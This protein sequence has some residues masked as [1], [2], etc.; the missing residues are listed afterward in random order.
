LVQNFDPQVYPSKEPTS[1]SAAHDIVSLN[2]IDETTLHNAAHLSRTSKEQA[3]T[4]S[5]LNSGGK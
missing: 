4:P 3:K 2:Q 5:M 1:Y